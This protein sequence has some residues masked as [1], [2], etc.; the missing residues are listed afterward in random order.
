MNVYKIGKPPVIYAR[1]RQVARG[2]GVVTGVC[3]TKLPGFTE[4]PIGTKPGAVKQLDRWFNKEDFANVAC[5]V[6]WT[7]CIRDGSGYAE[8]TRHYIAAL[9]H[10]GVGVTVESK[11]FEDIR[12]DYGM[13]GGISESLVDRDLKYVTK[14]IH[15]TPEN[16]P[17][18]REEGCYNIGMFAWETDALPD[19]WI[20]H[21][22]A[23]D[24]VWVPCK[25]NAEVCK[26]AKI[27]KPIHVFG[28][29]L[30]SAEYT[31]IK[32]LKLP[33]LD[34]RWFKFYSMFQWTERKN[35]LGLL[36]AYFTEFT[37]DDPVI[38][39]LKTYRS[40][41][42]DKERK[43]ILDLVQYARSKFC[44]DKPARLI[45]I[46]RMLTRQEM[47]GLHALG[48]CFVLPHRSE[49]W[50]LPH[51]EA[52]AM[53]KPV[54]TTDFGGNLEFTKYDNSYLVGHKSVPVEG[55]KWIP[56]YN[57]SMRWAEPS[58]I[59]CR[60]LMRHVVDNREEAKEKGKLAQA[61]VY[62]KFSWDAIGDK[63]K[64]RLVELWK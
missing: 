37:S 47:L 55:M 39:L 16:W 25:W 29:C 33:N 26:A 21:F 23:V 44:G 59:H 51:F 63:M 52:C 11:S 6:K 10:V 28:H 60:K 45:L 13:A 53:G 27:R 14:V 5:N 40:N 4:A 15:L 3:D 22:S 49:G 46:D 8:A 56:W 58:V 64:A 48:D 19:A 62:E 31:D 38:L 9:N 54:I 36:E 7:G 61:L 41:Y 20:P 35:P 34:P 30:N 43:I 50:G 57:D 2:L 12:G 32:P 18:C 24:E 17:K 1:L 42:T